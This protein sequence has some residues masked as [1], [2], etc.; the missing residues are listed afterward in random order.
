MI[1]V[2]PEGQCKSKDWWRLGFIQCYAELGGH[3]G[4]LYITS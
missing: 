1:D 2:E 4:L 3:P